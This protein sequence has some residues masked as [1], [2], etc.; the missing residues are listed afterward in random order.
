MKK[1]KE[2]KLGELFQVEGKEYIIVKPT[3]ATDDSNGHG[4]LVFLIDR[5]I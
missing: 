1:I 5:I 4:Q 3:N 2:V